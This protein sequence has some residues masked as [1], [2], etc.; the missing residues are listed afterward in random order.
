MN[1]PSIIGVVC[2]VFLLNTS[3]DL[4]AGESGSSYIFTNE[5]LGP[6]G[7]SS[8]ETVS[9]PPEETDQAGTPSISERDLVSDR[10]EIYRKKVEDARAKRQEETEKRSWCSR[11]KFLRK[12]IERAE[13]N[14]KAAKEYHDR[15]ERDNAVISRINSCK[16]SGA[17]N[18]LKDA[19]N[20]LERA[21]KELSDLENEAH[22]QWIP[23]GWV[24]CQFD[25]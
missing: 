19:K 22:R 21:R 3:L 17:K 6:Y 11:G 9:S 15:I 7:S 2:F 24:R 13:S 5:D 14:F 1:K 23:P 12:E 16:L 4:S 20:R 10:W 8:E 25:Y 18:W